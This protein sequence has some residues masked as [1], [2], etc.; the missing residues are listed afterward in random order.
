MCL[1]VCSSYLSVCTW[2]KHNTIHGNLTE[3]LALSC[4]DNF[5]DKGRRSFFDV[6]NLAQITMAA[7]T[8]A[9]ESSCVV[10]LFLDCQTHLSTWVVHELETAKA[11]AIPIIPVTKHGGVHVH[12]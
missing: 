10:I 3:K 1:L 11:A 2:Q 5:E 8:S 12:D 7:L 9:V 6:D 4:K